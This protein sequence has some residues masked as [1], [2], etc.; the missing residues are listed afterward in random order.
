MHKSGEK[1]QDVPGSRNVED[2]SSK[3]YLQRGNYILWGLK[4]LNNNT[5]FYSE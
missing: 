2:D 1:K 3:T 5:D 4:G